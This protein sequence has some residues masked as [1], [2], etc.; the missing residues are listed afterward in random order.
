MCDI[1]LPTSLT[2]TF[3]ICPCK[4]FFSR[5]LSLLKSEFCLWSEFLVDGR[6]GVSDSQPI[7]YK[8]SSTVIELNSS[9]AGAMEEQSS[10]GHF[11]AAEKSNPRQEPVD[12]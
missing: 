8:L 7:C 10:S 9:N 5:D 3:I 6:C 1:G 4:L 11:G 2:C 12:F